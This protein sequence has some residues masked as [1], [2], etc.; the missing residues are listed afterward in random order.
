MCIRDRCGAASHEGIVDQLA[1]LRITLDEIGWQLGLVACSVRNLMDGVAVAL[2]GSPK[3]A[4]FDRD[5][6]LASVLYCRHVA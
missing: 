1:G 5:C 2:L 4:M 6:A 3:L